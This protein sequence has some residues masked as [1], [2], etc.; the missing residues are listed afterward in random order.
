[1]SEK[2]SQMPAAAALTG[3]ELVPLVQGGDN[4]KS[5]VQA[6]ANLGGASVGPVLETVWAEPTAQ[7]TNDTEYNAWSVVVERGRYLYL[8]FYASTGHVSLSPTVY[9][10]SADGGKSWSD[11]VTIGAMT[12]EALAFGLTSTG[13]LIYLTSKGSTGILSINRTGVNDDTW[14]TTT[15][16]KP[17]GNDGYVFG[18]IKELPSGRLLCPYYLATAGSQKGGFLS[19]TDEGVSWAYYADVAVNINEIVFEVLDGTTD[20]DTRLII[21][22]RDAVNNNAKNR[23]YYSANGGASST[24]AG[25]VPIDG[26]P[27]YGYPGDI[28]KDGDDIYVAFGTRNSG[29]QGIQWFKTTTAVYDDLTEY[30]LPRFYY[31]AESYVKGIDN[32]WGYPALFK[33]N[34]QIYSVFYDCKPTQ[35]PKVTTTET[36]L[37]T[38]QLTGVFYGEFIRASYPSY[39]TIPYTKVPLAKKATNLNDTDYYWR[40]DSALGIHKIVIPDDGYYHAFCSLNFPT[41]NVTGTYRKLGVQLINPGFPLDASTEYPENPLTGNPAPEAVVLLSSKSVPPTAVADLMYIEVQNLF[42]AK[43][44]YEVVMFSVHD[45]TTAA[46]TTTDALMRIKKIPTS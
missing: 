5:T 44:D 39:N 46:L 34:N 12:H 40:E 22:A 18:K 9:K 7:V 1:M 30:G 2:I 17:L 36:R 29:Y 14:V 42:F 38:I 24:L 10:R 13:R 20:S 45:A 4:V 32:D 8:G 41:S 37:V 33:N 31:Q 11:N 23:H 15:Q 21:I 16:A 19:S 25:N 26:N 43:K 28:F 6:I 27:S 3:A 35:P